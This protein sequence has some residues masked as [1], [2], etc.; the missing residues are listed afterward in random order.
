[1]SHDCTF[2]N[3][4]GHLTG[5]SAAIRAALLVGGA[6][7]IALATFHTCSSKSAGSIRSWTRPLL[8]R[9]HREEELTAH[10]TLG[11]FV[12]EDSLEMWKEQETWC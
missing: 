3:V 2:I 4:P 11:L 5:L 8:H 6:V 12:R 7:D 1:M 9:V 10:H